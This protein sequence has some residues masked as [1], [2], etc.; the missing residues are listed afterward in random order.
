MRLRRHLI[1]LIL[2]SSSILAHED[3]SNI[4]DTLTH[5]IEEATD[6]KELAKLYYKRSIEASAIR[7]SKL[8][9]AD[10]LKSVNLDPENFEYRLTLSRVVEGPI[11][12]E[13]V[14]ELIKKAKNDQ[15]K[16]AVYRVKAER[17]Y[18][19]KEYASANFYCDKAIAHD[20]QNDLSLTLFKSHLLWQLDKLLERVDFLTKSLEKNTSAV[21]INTWIDA[22]IDAGKGAVVKKIII[23]E[24]NESRFKSSWLI[25][26]S[27]CEKS[28]AAKV[29]AQQAI[30]EIK[31]RL[32]LERPD[33]TLLM[34]LSRAYAIKG[35]QQKA[36][37]Y[38]ARAKKL[39]HDEWAMNACHSGLTLC[40]DPLCSS[41]PESHYKTESPELY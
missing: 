21:L 2:F 30:T 13:T 40:A 41:S 32:N 31:T 25:R 22:H 23:K 5:Q 8:A 39:A 18:S 9:R 6:D 28:S 15:Q 27:L 3:P 4:I 34:D 11:S 37:F 10:I 16:C 14:D 35:D 33:V 1:V 24:M 38:A 36:E 20:N 26:L 12:D 29:Y 19:R 17:L 7:N